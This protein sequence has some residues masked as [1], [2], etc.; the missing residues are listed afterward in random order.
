MYQHIYQANESLNLPTSHNN[1]SYY[2]F[3][4]TY[5]DTNYTAQL[6][7]YDRQ[8]IHWDFNRATSNMMGNKRALA[9]SAF[10]LSNFNQLII[11]T[12]F[13]FFL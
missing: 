12:V 13:V 7:A 8:Q 9:N 6:V 11:K 3:N 4:S 2:P 1:S 10:R 5:Y